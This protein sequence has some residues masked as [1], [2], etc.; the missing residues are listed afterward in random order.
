MPVHADAPPASPAARAQPAARSVEGGAAARRSYLPSRGSVRAL[1][2]LVL[3]AILVHAALPQIATLEGTARELQH[4]RWWAVALAAIAQV[5]SLSGYGYTIQSVARL[6]RDRITLPFAVRLALAGSS[7]GVLSGGP[8]GFGAATHRW[9]LERGVTAEG[10]TLCSWLPSLMNLTV[11]VGVTVVG[12]TYLMSHHILGHTQ[13]ETVAILAGVSG[14]LLLVATW[15]LSSA[16]RVASTIVYA[17]RRW[18]RLRRRNEERGDDERTVMHVTRAYE[19]L[20]GRWYAPLLGAS[21]KLGFDML[22]LLALF[23]GTGHAVS[24]GLLVAGYALPQLAGSVSFLPGGI[25]VVEGGMTGLYVALGVP[26]STAVLTVLAYRGL[27]F[28]GPILMGLPVA[29]GLERAKRGAEHA[30]PGERSHVS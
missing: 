25:G 9:L 22:T 28:W 2:L 18:R 5:A 30:G 23:A 13:L 10:A 6:T 12:A 8:V 1:L 26:T 19:L 15:V 7:V 24:P 21:A 11:L 3:I 14:V 16:Q 29:V 27:S 4:M 17:R 20:R